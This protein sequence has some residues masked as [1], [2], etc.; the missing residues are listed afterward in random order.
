NCKESYFINRGRRPPAYR[1]RSFAAT[2]LS[3]WRG[4]VIC[5]TVHD[6]NAYAMGGIAGHAGL[7]STAREVYRLV[8][9]WL[10]ALKGEGILDPS[11]T[12]LFV[13]RQ[14]GRGVP[15]QSS[16]GLGWD[17]PSH[18]STS[19]APPSTSNIPPSSSGRY[20]SSASFGHLGFTGTSIWVDRARDLAVILLTNRIHPSRA[21]EKIRSFRP[22]LHDVI[23]K[24]VAGG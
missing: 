15:A 11:L 20:F 4:K 18:P 24:E 1:R 21:N 2:E 22:A 7:F 9:F 17:T 6:D 23:F 19:D 14:K 8:R 5:G 12:A 10:D 3:S 16:W 13:T